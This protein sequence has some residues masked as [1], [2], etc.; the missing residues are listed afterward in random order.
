MVVAPPCRGGGQL[1]RQ[2]F[3]GAYDLA[4]PAEVEFP[5]TARSVFSTIP[6]GSPRFDSS[7]LVLRSHVLSRTTVSVGDRNSN[8]QDV[9]TAD[10]PWSLLGGL[11]VQAAAGGP[12]VVNLQPLPS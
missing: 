9:G 12:A 7:H 2:L 10:E 5:V 4:D 3:D 1:E 6:R 8:P 11:A